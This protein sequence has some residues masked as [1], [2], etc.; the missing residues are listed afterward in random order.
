MMEWQLKSEKPSRDTWS[1]SRPCWL[2]HMP[3]WNS[4]HQLDGADHVDECRKIEFMSLMFRLTSLMFPN[5]TTLVEQNRMHPD[6]AAFPCAQFYDSKLLDADSTYGKF[7]NSF[8]SKL[9][10]TIGCALSSESEANIRTHLFTVKNAIKRKSIFIGLSCNL[11]TLGVT[12]QILISII[13][14]FGD[15]TSLKVSLITP[16]R[17]QA[18]LY[19]QAF[20]QI[21]N[22][23]DLDEK[24]V[25]RIST[26][27]VDLS[28][29]KQ[30]VQ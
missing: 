4:R 29:T 18:S 24:H 20:A 3:I 19:R 2:R 1:A 14:I 21:R 10:H 13:S 22:E 9:A 26:I 5:V 25:P 27:D 12:V 30:T 8:K 11:E 15:K 23:C 6:I 17:L 7:S 16:Y 28:A